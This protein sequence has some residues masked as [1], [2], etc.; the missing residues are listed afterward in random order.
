MHGL[1]S[2]ML[3]VIAVCAIVIVRFW[4]AFLMGTLV[5][6]TIL[7]ILGVISFVNDIAH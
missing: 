2:E 6:A 1:T 7:I 5:F 4:R 3:I